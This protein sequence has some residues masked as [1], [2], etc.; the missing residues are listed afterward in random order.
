MIDDWF[1]LGFDIRQAGEAPASSTSMDP[2][3]LRRPNEL[4]F[5]ASSGRPPWGPFGLIK[6]PGFLFTSD[7]SNLDCS[8]RYLCFICA[9]GTWNALC[10]RYSASIFSGGHLEEYPDVAC[11]AFRGFDAVDLNGLISGIDGCGAIAATCSSKLNRNRLF[12][13]LSD[14]RDFAE[15]RSIAVPE[16]APF[17]AIG[18][19]DGGSIHL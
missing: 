2:S 1:V 3:V 19:F 14:V 13:E 18:V 12:D 9:P 16:H 15:S 8:A 4:E 6:D 7:I 10:A 17:L 5:L 11:W